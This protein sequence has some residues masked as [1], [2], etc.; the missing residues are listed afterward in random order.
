MISA[1]A[2]LTGVSGVGCPR[3]GFAL[4]VSAGFLLLFIVTAV[5]VPASALSGGESL[6]YRQTYY[7]VYDMKTG[8]R[9]T[10]EWRTVALDGNLTCSLLR[11]GDR[12]NWTQGGSGSGEYLAD[13]DCPVMLEWANYWP[14]ETGFHFSVDRTLHPTR[15]VPYVLGIALV[16]TLTVGAMI[17]VKR[18]ADRKKA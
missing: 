5:P 10:W 8:D 13:Y 18:R 14:N 16:Y 15:F 9:L 17:L 11:K 7:R 4:A 12:L 1:H 2:G 6:E 3:R